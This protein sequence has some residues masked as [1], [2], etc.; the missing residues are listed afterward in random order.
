MSS[1]TLAVWI[2]IAALGLI[3]AIA[4]FKLNGA[5]DHPLLVDASLTKGKGPAIV[6]VPA[7]PVDARPSRKQWSWT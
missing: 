2:Y 5:V 6:C 1:R 7:I 4:L 3:C